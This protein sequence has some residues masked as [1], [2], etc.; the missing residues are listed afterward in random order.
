MSSKLLHWPVHLFKPKV[1]KLSLGLTCT[2]NFSPLCLQVLVIFKNSVGTLWWLTENLTCKNHSFV[3]MAV[4]CRRDLWLEVGNGKFICRG[5]HNPFHQVMHKTDN[6]TITLKS[7]E[8]KWHLV[9]E[10]AELR[11]KS[12]T[13]FPD[14]PGVQGEAWG[15]LWA[16]R[17]SCSA[18]RKDRAPW[19]TAMMELHKQP[20]LSC[21]KPKDLA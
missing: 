14:Q 6:G 21:A 10:R 1:G 2:G 17:C 9:K 4:F 11:N 3:E 18:Q 8:N 15:L 7:S 13:V 19:M 5:W 20:S 16:H 12:V